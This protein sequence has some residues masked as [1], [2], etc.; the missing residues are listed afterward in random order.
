MGASAAGWHAGKHCSVL[1]A[2][3]ALNPGIIM[4]TMRHVA[5]RGTQ[6]YSRVSTRLLDGEHATGTVVVQ[7]SLAARMPRGSCIRPPCDYETG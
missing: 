2:A 3:D 1:P 7:Q 4:Q 6:G 5:L